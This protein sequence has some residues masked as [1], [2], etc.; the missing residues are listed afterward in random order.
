MTEA[1]SKWE[2]QAVG[3]MPQKSQGLSLGLGRV[4]GR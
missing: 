2:G 4:K 1:N 3:D